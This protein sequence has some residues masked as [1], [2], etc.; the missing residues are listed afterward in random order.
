MRLNRSLSEAS[1]VWPKTYSSSA[2]ILLPVVAA[3]L[4]LAV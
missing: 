4:W 1:D 3:A 2:M